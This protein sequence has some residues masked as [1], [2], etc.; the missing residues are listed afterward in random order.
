MWIYGIL[1]IVCDIQGDTEAI[2][3]DHPC[4]GP[5]MVIVRSCSDSPW[6]TNHAVG[7][8]NNY[9]WFKKPSM[10]QLWHFSWFYIL[11]V[12]TALC[13]PTATRHQWIHVPHWG[14]A[15]G[16]NQSGCKSWFWDTAE[17]QMLISPVNSS[18][19]GVYMHQLIGSAL[20]QIMAC[21]LFCAKPLSEPMLEYCHLNGTI[22]NTLQWNF[23]HNTKL[24]I[25]KNAS[26]N[27][28]C[29]MAAILSRGRWVKTYQAWEFSL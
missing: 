5:L 26:E 29:E 24:V 22:R 25:H 23:N 11:L 27:I 1:Y 7:C 19:S 14:G 16:G 3:S 10:M 6:P 8:P 28:V 4:H 13:L 12:R 20:L 15:G 2:R 21:R 18:P 9:N 17:H